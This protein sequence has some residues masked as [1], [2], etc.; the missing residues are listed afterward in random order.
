VLV[1]DG[2]EK[3]CDGYKRQLQQDAVFSYQVIIQQTLLTPLSHFPDSS[4]DGM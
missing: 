3:N 4:I 2:S 1:V